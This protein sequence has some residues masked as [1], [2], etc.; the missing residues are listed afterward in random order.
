MKLAQAVKKFAT[1]PLDGWNGTSWD[2]DIAKVVHTTYDRFVTQRTFGALKRVFLSPEAIDT[3]YEVVRTPD[4]SKFLLTF[5]N[6]DIVR[7]ETYDFV[8]LV[9]EANY[10]ISI[11][12]FTTTPSASGMASAAVRAVTA[13]VFG[14]IERI[15]FSR[16]RE[17]DVVTYPRMVATV[18]LTTVVDTD[19]ELT[20]DGVDYAIDEVYREL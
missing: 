9:F 3:K 1:T 19:D 10:S 2:Q 12:K 15:S 20:V 16:S 7:D 13:T 6:L 11:A 17:F 14:D 18:P 8:Y 4:G 5:D